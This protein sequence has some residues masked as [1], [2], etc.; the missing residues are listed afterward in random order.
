MTEDNNKQTI[1]EVWQSARKAKSLTLET[2]SDRLKLTV[3]QLEIFE[4]PELDLSQLDP[5]QR[6]YMRNYAEVLGIDISEFE[7]HFPDGSN[8]SSTLSSVE[9]ANESPE[10]LLSGKILKWL[11]VLLMILIIAGLV[12]INQ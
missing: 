12:L 8:V 9:Q 1:G 11:S 6:G 4:S 10:P 2:I 3:E 7:D 5:F